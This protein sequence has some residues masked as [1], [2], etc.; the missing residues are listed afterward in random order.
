MRVVCDAGGCCAIKIIRDF[1]LGPDDKSFIEA[2]PGHSEDQYTASPT[3]D[4]WHKCENGAHGITGR[5]AFERLLHHIKSR[6]PAGMVVVNLADSQMFKS[7]LVAWGELFS[8]L[9]FECKK[10]LNSNSGRTI[11]HYSLTY[12]VG[13]DEEE[14]YEEDLCDVA[15]C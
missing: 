2:S 11:Y 1:G 9:G 5:E 3:A 15:N 13:Y 10:F 4:S 14:D 7:A 6:R 12:D 8:S